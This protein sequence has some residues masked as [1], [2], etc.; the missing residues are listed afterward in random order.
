MLPRWLVQSLELGGMRQ[1]VTVRMQIHES[2]IIAIL[3]RRCALTSRE[4]LAIGSGR[5]RRSPAILTM[6]GPSISRTAAP[7]PTSSTIA[8]MWCV[9]EAVRSAA[10]ASLACGF[11]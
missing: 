11:I 4:R 10:A 3:W 9:C 8:P 6:R 5:P 2:A 1:Q 7:S